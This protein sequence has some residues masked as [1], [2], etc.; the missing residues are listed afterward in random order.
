M[1]NLFWMTS[2][3]SFPQHNLSGGHLPPKCSSQ[4]IKRTVVDAEVTPAKKMKAI[5][6]YGSC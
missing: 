6:G 1:F 2:F 3:F 5:L 4:G